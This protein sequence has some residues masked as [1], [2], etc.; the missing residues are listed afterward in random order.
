M[1]G[2]KLHLSLMLSLYE[3]PRRFDLKQGVG[4]LRL[5]FHLHMNALLMIHILKLLLTT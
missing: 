5:I 4:K 3:K 2:F 1:S